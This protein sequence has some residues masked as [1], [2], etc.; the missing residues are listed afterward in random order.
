ATRDRLL[1]ARLLQVAFLQFLHPLTRG[2]A[3]D[4]LAPAALAAQ[5]ALPAPLDADG[6]QPITRPVVAVLEASECIG[7][8]LAHVA[9]HMRGQRTVRVVANW[10]WH[11]IDTAQVLG[12]RLQGCHYVS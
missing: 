6:T 3:T 5:V 8:H 9:D 11:H 10:N 1:P 2:A 7:V 12:M 4:E